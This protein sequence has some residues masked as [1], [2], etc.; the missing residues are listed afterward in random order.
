MVRL[1]CLILSLNPEFIMSE[2]KLPTLEEC[3]KFAGHN[4]INKSLP[5]H[6][7]YWDRQQIKTK[8]RTP[9]NWNLMNF[10]L[11]EL[12]KHHDINLKQ[13]GRKFHIED[14]SYKNV[15]QWFNMLNDDDKKQRVAGDM[16]DMQLNRLCFKIM[17]FD[18]IITQKNCNEVKY[19][20]EGTAK[21]IEP[22]WNQDKD[23]RVFD[24]I[25]GSTPLTLS[26]AETEMI[27]RY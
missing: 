3:L 2:E 9:Q 5:N 16:W 19:L 8:M 18:K 6:I 13:I 11:R 17:K 22:Y 15:M 14:S 10:I 23:N 21:L 4:N 1:I 7:L 24:V 25:P 26:V 20:G 27:N 12:E